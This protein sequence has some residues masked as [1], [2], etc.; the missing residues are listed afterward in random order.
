[1]HMRRLVL[2]V[3]LLLGCSRVWADG[4]RNPPP[5]GAALGLSNNGAALL[6]TPAAVALNPANLGT[7]TQP[8]AEVSAAMARS[9]TTITSPIGRAVSHDDWQVLP[10]VFAVLPL[11]DSEVVAGV[12][13]TT[14][15]GQAVEWDRGFFLSA[16]SPY[17]AQMSL[18]DLQPAAALRLGPGWSVGAALDVYLARLEFKQVFPWALALGPGA[19]DG[20]LKADGDA[21]AVGG[22]IGLTWEPAGGHRLAL[23]YRTSADLDFDGDA[24]LQGAPVPLPGTKGDFSTSMPLPSSAVLAYGCELTDSIRVEADVEWLDWSRFQSQTVDLRIPAAPVPLGRTLPERW[25]DT[26]TYGLG[27]SWQPA[28]DWC[29]RAGYTWLPSP[30]PAG[31]L[32]PILPDADRQVFSL[33]VGFTRGPHHWDVGVAFSQYDDTTVPTGALPMSYELEADLV[34]LSYRYT[35]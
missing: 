13:L 28:P 1:M 18:L 32:S 23:V 27:V 22:H 8:A 11:P 24:R 16:Q 25:D 19:P 14:P 20:T 3:I 34:G 12:G 9:K 15:Y 10:N 31:T 5:G 6:D 35:F 30:V 33:G 29:L 4:F 21:Q 26:W 2:P 17:S 7:Q